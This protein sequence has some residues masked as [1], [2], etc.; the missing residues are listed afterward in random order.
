M[1]R[2]ISIWHLVLLLTLAVLHVQTIQVP[3]SGTSPL[4]AGREISEEL[5]ADL[6]ELSRIVDISYCVGLTGTGIQKPFQCLSRCHE[7]G[8]FELITVSVIP[9]ST[10]NKHEADGLYYRHGTQV[11]SL[12]IAVAILPYLTCHQPLA[13]LLHF[14]GLIQSQTPSLT[15]PPC[16]KNTFRILAIMMGTKRTAWGPRGKNVRVARF[17]QGSWPPGERLDIT[18]LRTL[19]SSLKSIPNTSLL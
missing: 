12:G 17:M 16:H 19:M 14:E 11:R 1:M 5:F 18:S 10:L 2:R 7:F 9:R 4:N 13:S 3:L 8:G 15:W 6:E